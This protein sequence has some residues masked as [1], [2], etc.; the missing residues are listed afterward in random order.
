MNAA[1]LSHAGGRDD[2]VEVLWE[3]AEGVFC[4][5]LQK[6][7][8]GHG[9]AFAP[10]LAGAQHPTIE[11][12]NRLA[13]EYELKEYSDGAWALRPAELVSLGVQNFDP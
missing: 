8:E 2:S 1:T 6:D 9:H 7:A 13:R 10:I 11:S 12:I 4:R 3:D 5:A